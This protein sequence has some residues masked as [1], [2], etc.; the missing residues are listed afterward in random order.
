[1]K[2]TVLTFG[3]I[4]GLVIAVLMAALTFF[5]ERIGFGKAEYLGYSTMILAFTLVFFGIRSYRENVLDG[6]IS[7]GKA[8]KVGILIA[9]ISSL[10][11]V[12]AWDIV[13]FGGFLPDFAEKYSAYVLENLKQSG[14]TPEQL[15]AEAQKHKDMK[16][17]LDNPLLSSV[18]IFFVEPFPVALLVTLISAAILRKKRKQVA[19]DLHGRESIAV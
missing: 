10:C 4:S 15:A 5:A 8:F 3:L 13:Y 11:Y 17:M 2:K 7:F 6:Y 14:A 16:I 12:L 19:T 18:I 1:M 9:V